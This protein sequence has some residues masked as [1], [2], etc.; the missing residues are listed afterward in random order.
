MGVINVFQK[1]CVVQLLYSLILQKTKN[2]L[3]FL[4]NTVKTK[5][6]FTAL[7]ALSLF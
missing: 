3:T 4:L 5:Q 6:K 1:A 7:K 2:D